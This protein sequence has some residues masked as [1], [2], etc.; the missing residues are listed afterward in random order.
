MQSN[1]LSSL[2]KSKV[3][4]YADILSTSLRGGM[5]PPTQA[6]ELRRSPLA[7]VFEQIFTDRERLVGLL[8]Q[9]S[10]IL[11]KSTN[12]NIYTQ[13]FHASLLEALNKLASASTATEEMASTSRSV[14]RSAAEAAALAEASALEV[15]HGVGDIRRLADE[16]M[17]IG[18]SVETMTSAMT[19]FI[20]NTQRIVQLTDVLRGI[21]NQTNLLALNASIEASRA[22]DAG[23]GFAIVADEVRTLA[24]LSADAVREIGDISDRIANESVLVQQAVGKGRGHLG[25]VDEAMHKTMD[26]L[27][28]ASE[29]VTLSNDYIQQ[30]AVAAEQQSAVSQDMARTLALISHETDKLDSSINGLEGVIETVVDGMGAQ[31][32]TYAYWPFDEVLLSVAMSDHVLWVERATNFLAPHPHE[33]VVL[34]D[35]H[36]CRLGQWLAGVGKERF[37]D[38]E[39]YRSLIPLHDRIH[40]LGIEIADLARQ[41]QRQQAEAKVGELVRLRDQVLEKL[42]ALRREVMHW[43]R[44]AVIESSSQPILVG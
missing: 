27:S 9:Q 8:D 40:S 10:D 39:T 33:H 3:H 30:I 28:H 42:S 43:Q 11:K 36:T 22:G 26:V 37:G 38:S 14:A 21:A 29:S 44:D 13:I 34:S 20:D 4:R 6:M 16:V 1:A 23:R 35:Q 19:A 17:L 5:A 7:A 24:T 25:R 32:K 31:L 12:V 18:Q 41:G 2:F 15:S